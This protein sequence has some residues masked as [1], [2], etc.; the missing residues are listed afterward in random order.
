MKIRYNRTI[1]DLTE[2]AHR[3]LLFLREKI[4]QKQQQ[5]QQQQQQQKTPDPQ[6][7]KPKKK[8]VTR[9]EPIAT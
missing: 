5:Q 9:D 8:G 3:N 6:Q 2:T 1:P 7:V 4:F